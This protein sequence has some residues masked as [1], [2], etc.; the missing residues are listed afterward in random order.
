MFLFPHGSSWQHGEGARAE[1][2]P[3][4]TRP[5]T[6]LYDVKSSWNAFEKSLQIWVADATANRPNRASTTKYDAF[7]VPCFCGDKIIQRLCDVA[8]EFVVVSDQLRLSALDE[9]GADFMY[10]DLLELVLLWRNYRDMPVP[11]TLIGDPAIHSDQAVKTF[12]FVAR[13]TKLR[14]LLKPGEGG[15][16]VLAQAHKVV[17][18]CLSVTLNFVDMFRQVLSEPGAMDDTTQAVNVY[19]LL[20][21]ITTMVSKWVDV[22]PARHLLYTRVDELC[23]LFGDKCSVARGVRLIVTD[24]QHPQCVHCEGVVDV[25]GRWWRVLL[26]LRHRKVL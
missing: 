25:G 8:S 19:L 26:P 4:Q 14:Q 12:N 9:K 11:L 21:H 17:M 2:C 10:N 20:E 3:D 7:M 16:R 23:T 15:L 24:L 22:L 6:H 13:A 18:S 1:V 5:R